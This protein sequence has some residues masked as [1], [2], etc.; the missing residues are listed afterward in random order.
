MPESPSFVSTFLCVLTLTAPCIAIRS[1]LRRL[2]RSRQRSGAPSQEISMLSLESCINDIFAAFAVKVV[3]RSSR[4]FRVDH[5]KRP[6]ASPWR[7][8]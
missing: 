3:P 5:A 6:Q 8:A 1:A 4:T 2:L 7:P